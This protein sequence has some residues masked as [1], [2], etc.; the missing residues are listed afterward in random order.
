[1]L[2]SSVAQLGAELDIGKLHIFLDL[3]NRS[4]NPE[5][6]MIKVWTSVYMKTI[7]FSLN[8][9]TSVDL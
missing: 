9:N 8:T 1:M 3:G 6:L 7:D 5:P 2:V 4:I